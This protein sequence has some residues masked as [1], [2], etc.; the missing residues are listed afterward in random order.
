MVA[1]ARVAITAMAPVSSDEAESGGGV[2]GLKG[3][4]SDLVDRVF[5]SKGSDCCPGIADPGTFLYTLWT[6]GAI[7]F[8]LR[9]AIQQN[10]NGGRR[11]RRRRRIAVEEH[12]ILGQLP[13]QK[14]AFVFTYFFPFLPQSRF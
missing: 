8:F 3:S 12:W 11:R 4:V 2:D 7:T 1:E 9:N 5:Y 14:N 6:I 13:G 10:I